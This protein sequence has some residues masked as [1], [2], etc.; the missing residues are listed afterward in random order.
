MTRKALVRTVVRV[1]DERA[2]KG[3]ACNGPLSS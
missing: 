1:S 2:L 3:L